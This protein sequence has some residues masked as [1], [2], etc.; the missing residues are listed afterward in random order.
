MTEPTFSPVILYALPLQ[1]LETH[2]MFLQIEL[3]SLGNLSNIMRNSFSKVE[4]ESI[5]N[6]SLGLP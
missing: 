2:A 4:T 3:T 1:S 5:E 6:I